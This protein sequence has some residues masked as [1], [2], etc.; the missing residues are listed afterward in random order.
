MKL[1][2]WTNEQNIYVRNHLAWLLLKGLDGQILSGM[3]LL[4]ILPKA[5]FAI[6][7]SSSKEVLWII[8]IAI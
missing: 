1:Q 5:V 6:S 2:L 3:F 8:E 4:R 7:S